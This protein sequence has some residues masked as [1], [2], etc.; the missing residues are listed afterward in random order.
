VVFKKLLKALGVGGPSIETV[1]PDP[2]VRPG[3]TLHGEI[4]IEGGE[5]PCDITGMS[6]ALVTEVEWESGDSEGRSTRKFSEAQV[7]GGFVLAPGA[8]HQLPFALQ[9]P[10]ENPLTHVYGQHLHGMKM[11]LSTRLSVAKAVDATDLDPV[12]VHPLPAQERL[13]E[14]FARLGFRF[15]RADV[16][17][18]WIRGVNQT[19]PFYQ[20][21]EFYPAA[22]YARAMNQL[23][24]TFVANPASMVMVMELDKRG[25]LLTEGHD[26]FG[27]FTID[28][29]TAGQVN[30]E[31]Q[32]DG[33][34]Q[35][36][37]KRRGLFF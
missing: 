34:L 9:V 3:G 10:W 30:W 17:E 27:S 35:Q 11:G 1:L 12:A 22:Q 14:A 20:E 28:Y 8:R 21:I 5:H 4:R 36:A 23:E 13:L 32:L 6:V 29:A 19:L 31:Q 33:W 16:E 37:C 2:N 7:S 15:S 25:G 24:V 18:G 26:A